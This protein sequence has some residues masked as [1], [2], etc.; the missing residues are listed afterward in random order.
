[1]HDRIVRH[2]LVVIDPGGVEDQQLNLSNSELRELLPNSKSMS[3]CYCFEGKGTLT[4]LFCKQI[5]ALSQTG[6]KRP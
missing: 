6:E 1:M 4:K 5:V 3:T 2:L